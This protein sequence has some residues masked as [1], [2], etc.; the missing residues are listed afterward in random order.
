MKTVLNIYPNKILN[1]HI[2]RKM[3]KNKHVSNEVL[4]KEAIN[5]LKRIY[6]YE[7]ELLIV[8][9]MLLKS[10]TT[11][12]LVDSLTLLHQYTREHIKVLEKKFPKISKTELENKLI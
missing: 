11:F 9:P 12:E 3:D 7:K 1:N 5:E 6:W 2:I 10:A 8:I 4:R